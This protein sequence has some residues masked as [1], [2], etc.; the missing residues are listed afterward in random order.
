MQPCGTIAACF[1]FEQ[2]NRLGPRALSPRSAAD[3]ERAQD[4]VGPIAFDPAKADPLR[5]IVE[6]KEAAPFF[7]EILDR[8][9]SISDDVAA[10]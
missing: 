9:K 7:G 6:G 2:G 3:D 4:A 10:F 5:T 1:A 8:D